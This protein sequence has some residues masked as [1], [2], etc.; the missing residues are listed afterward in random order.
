MRSWKG[1]WFERA[2]VRYQVSRLRPF[3][4]L[5]GIGVLVRSSPPSAETTQAPGAVRS[6]RF[7]SLSFVLRIYGNFWNRGRQV[8]FRPPGEGKLRATGR[9][10]SDSHA[11]KE[12][13]WK[14][15]RAS[16]CY[17]SRALV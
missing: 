7:A 3:G 8:H 14:Q 9:P 15:S 12:K 5:S 16:R 11:R 4:L 2:G 17:L 10:K 6:I 13:P 1:T